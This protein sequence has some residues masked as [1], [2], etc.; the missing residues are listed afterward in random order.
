MVDLTPEEWQTIREALD[1]L[2][3]DVDDDPEDFLEGA[4][5]HLLE[6]LGKLTEPIRESKIYFGESNA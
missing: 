1:S 2:K 3:Y 6:T 4:S 5:D